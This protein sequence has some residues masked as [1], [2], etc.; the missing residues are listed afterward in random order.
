MEKPDIPINEKERIEALKSYMILDSHVEKDFD[1]ITKLASIICKVPIALISLIDS[2]RQWFKSRIG[3]DVTETSREISF[4]GHA[5]NHSEELFIISDSRK[6][7]RFFDNPLVTGD[8]N[9]IFYAGSP[10]LDESG[11]VL[12]TLCVIDNHPKNLTEEQKLVLKYL[13]NQVVNLMKYRR[14][15]L[16]LANENYILKR[17]SEIL[18][19]TNFIAQVG[20]WEYDPKEDSLYWSAVTK[21]IYEVP[22]NYKPNKEE[23]FQF[24]DSDQIRNELESFFLSAIE[25]GSYWD[26]VAKIKTAKGNTKW[27]RTKGYP[28]FKDGKCI[29][30]YGSFQDITNEFINREIIKN[31][32][33]QLSIILDSL[34]EVVW[35]VSLPD[36]KPLYTSKSF[37]KIY[38][39][40]VLEYYNNINIWKQVIHPDDM[41]YIEEFEKQIFFS[42]FAA[43][44]YRIV[45]PDGSYRWVEN[46]TK[47]VKNNE[48]KPVYI[49]GIL[50]DITEKKEIEY[51]LVHLKEIAEAASKAK[52]EFLANMSHEIRTPLN[53]V[54]GFSEML[55]N[56]KLDSNQRR[57]MNIVNQSAHSLLDLINDILDFS[58]IEAGK[59]ELSQ[60]IVN[61]VDI[62]EQSIDLVKY[63]AIEKGLDLL[64]DIDYENFHNIEVDPIRLRQIL[65]NLL[66]NAIKF[67]DKGEVEISSKI[68][69]DVQDENLIHIEFSVRD[70]GIGIS[71]KDQEK[72]LEV[73]SQADTTTSRKYGGSGLGLSIS[74]NL[75]NLMNSKLLIQSNLGKGSK[76]SFVIES[77]IF[78]DLEK[79]RESYANIKNVLIIERLEKSG[80]NIKNILS[81]YN[82]T[83]EL[84]LQGDSKLINFINP[85]EELNFDLIIVDQ[86]VCF[87]NKLFLANLLYSMNQNKKSIPIILL[88]NSFN[89]VDLSGIEST[90]QKIIT[91]TKPLTESFITN[92]LDDISS[93]ISNKQLKNLDKD[94]TIILDLTK[95]LIAEDNPVNL[96]LSKSMV[97][98][99]LPNS[100][101]EVA[102]NGIEA[103]QKYESFLPDVILMDVQMPE[104]N[105]LDATISIR[106]INKN[107]CIIIALTAGTTQ[108]EEEKCM[109]A[110]MNDFLS[111]PI[112]IDILNSKILKWIRK[113]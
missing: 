12:G 100:S 108:G 68:L 49:T 24:Y 45:R 54:I 46:T 1:D 107:N 81:L 39:R 99:I 9:V 42:Q 3:L 38:G 76:F 69:K 60:E 44:S 102:T 48:G 27:V 33:E 64:V 15:N 51:E 57:Y 88:A 93:N 111:K 109:K 78:P 85:S 73:F 8:P 43:T 16:L 5:I 14:N 52:S 50:K 103:I 86:S 32:E 17:K 29:R 36:Y 89:K 113:L 34:E 91:L 87:I 105:G 65:V 110:G 55:M 94:K 63:K 53:G 70:T 92:I 74:N 75:L 66:S 23:A 106:K 96:L 47:I 90:T 11:F 71:Q 98:R 41:A 40:S 56:S 18:E 97:K 59:M 4:C 26:S 28:D 104:L 10:L 67:T 84:V 19:E 72:I 62:I 30:L 20:G 35:A 21:D 101:I 2:E 22:S 83:S 58:K 112:Q 13:S 25:A 79:P 82:I 6:D 80:K 7:S 77:K 61:R 31:K 95:V 37:E